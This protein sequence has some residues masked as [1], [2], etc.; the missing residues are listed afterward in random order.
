MKKARTNPNAVRMKFKADLYRMK[1]FCGTQEIE[2]IQPGRVSMELDYHTQEYEI[3]DATFEG[4]YSYP[5][6]AISSSCPTVTL[7]LFSEKEP[8]KPVTKVLDAKTV[9]RV[10]ADFE[11]F[12][13][14]Q[15]KLQ[16]EA[17]GGK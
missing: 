2:P 4:L 13:A 9:A 7:Q 3:S 11:P 1:L 10:T 12:R 14:A 8:D 6:D 17:V 16:T 5:Y 15:G